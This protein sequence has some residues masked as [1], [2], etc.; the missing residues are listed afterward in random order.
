MHK[1]REHALI[2]RPC[3]R[4]VMPTNLNVG[5][6][7]AL[8]PIEEG[9]EENPL[10][11]DSIP[12][13]SRNVI[14]SAA[15]ASRVRGIPSIR[16]HASSH[17]SSA[18]SGPLPVPKVCPSAMTNDVSTTLD[19]HRRQP[20][21]FTNTSTNHPN[22]NSIP[23]LPSLPPLNHNPNIQSPSNIRH[24]RHEKIIQGST[25]HNTTN[26]PLP[27]PTN[28]TQ[29]YTIGVPVQSFSTTVHRST[30]RP[31]PPVPSL[32][33][34]PVQRIRGWTHPSDQRPTFLQAPAHSIMHVIPTHPTPYFIPQPQ[35]PMTMIQPPPS[36]TVIQRPVFIPVPVVY[37]PFQTVS[38]VPWNS[39]TTV[40][41]NPLS[42][43]F[44]P[45]QVGRRPVQGV[46]FSQAQV[47]HA[48]VTGNPGPIMNNNNL[49]FG[50]R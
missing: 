16:R 8:S 23:T 28:N 10:R 18:S 5:H 20:S 49:C 12:N 45:A 29:T 27:L 25:S 44:Y 32:S 14:A 7:M 9:Q 36:I 46:Q 34:V 21:D 11:M 30:I 4:V 42:G 26:I 22:L 40:M 37:Q 13:V 2:P 17:A 15:R 3:P 47:Y 39:T 38:M 48:S 6:G 31:L 41:V 43:S 33:T 50:Q 19:I 1:Q 24:V 35:V